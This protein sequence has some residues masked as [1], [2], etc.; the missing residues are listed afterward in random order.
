MTKELVGPIK[1]PLET[2]L[3]PAATE[4]A[5]AF[6]DQVKHWRDMRRLERAIDSIKLL[7]ERGIPP[8]AIDPSLLFPILDAASLT[9]DEDLK[10]SWAAMLAN[11]ADPES[12]S[13]VL[14]SFPAILCQL[15]PLDVA[16]LDVVRAASANRELVGGD[17]VTVVERKHIQQE[18]GI[19]RTR[20][21]IVYD[22]LMR[23]GLLWQ[24]AGSQSMTPAES[25]SGTVNI[26]PYHWMILSELGMAFT[27]ACRYP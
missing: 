12:A 19:D 25:P 3:G 18:F 24:H 20:Y 8:K 10:A 23:L 16:I 6:G 21:L 4:L 27:K 7:Q 9:D 2:M 1:E 17:S 15:T 26:V 13:T 22:N 11:A 14:P 5:G